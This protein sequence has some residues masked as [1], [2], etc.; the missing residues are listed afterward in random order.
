M[1]VEAAVVLVMIAQVNGLP[2]PPLPQIERVDCQSDG[3]VGDIPIQRAEVVLRNVADL[4]LVAWAV[5]WHDRNH[6]D[7]WHVSTVDTILSSPDRVVAPGD[8]RVSTWTVACEQ[9]AEVVGAIFA[10]YSFVGHPRALEGFRRNR[11]RSLSGTQTLLSVLQTTNL[12]E[13]TVDSVSALGALIDRINGPDVVAGKMALLSL[14]ARDSSA[15]H[16]L[17]DKGP[18][19]TIPKHV[20]VGALEQ[21]QRELQAGL[22]IIE[23][24]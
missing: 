7:A 4:G 8:T 3:L 18:R 2:P 1:I 19:I 21:A 14:L 11:A 13:S 6:P 9:R 23:R 12:G 24:R 20:L 17:N 10:D 16:I 22:Q 5:R 15:S